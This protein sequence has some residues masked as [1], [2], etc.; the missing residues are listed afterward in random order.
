MGTFFTAGGKVG[1]VGEVGERTPIV[2]VK[3]E[4]RREEIMGAPTLPD[5]CYGKRV[6]VR[7]SVMSR[8]ESGSAYTED[9][10]V[11]NFSHL[12]FVPMGDSNY[13]LFLVIPSLVLLP[14]L[15]YTP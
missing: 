3:E 11:L 12:A 6:P 15:Y 7:S 5:A 1:E 2:T 8:S 14:A 9:N 10:H 13:L 4:E